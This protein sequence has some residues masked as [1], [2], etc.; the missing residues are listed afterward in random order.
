MA[1]DTVVAA[2]DELTVAI[3][4]LNGCDDSMYAACWVAIDRAV[5]ALIAAVRAERETE[6]GALRREQRDDVTRWNT[7]NTEAQELIASLTGQLDAA[8]QHVKILQEQ[9]AEREQPFPE[10]NMS[11]LPPNPPNL[12]DAAEMLWTV[13]ANVSEGDWTKQPKYWQ[14]AAARWRDYYFQAV[15]ITPRPTHP[16][17]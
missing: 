10:R 5:D 16:P 13:I 3:K 17:S 2:R 4:R 8:E 7:A 9:R 15:D 1:H 14:D 12:S 11:G 6:I